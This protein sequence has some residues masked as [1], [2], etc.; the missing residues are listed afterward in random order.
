MDEPPRGALILVYFSAAAVVGVSALELLLYLA[1]QYQ[2]HLPPGIVHTTF[3]SLPIML[4][5]VI[6]VRARAVAEWISNKFDK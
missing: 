6:L 3:L 2:H 1:E 5:F 4:G